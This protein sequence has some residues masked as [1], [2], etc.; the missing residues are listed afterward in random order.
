MDIRACQ[1]DNRRA[2]PSLRETVL[3]D[4]AC[5]SGERKFAVQTK[6]GALQRR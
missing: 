2:L 3:L 4:G 6:A 1:D 5:G